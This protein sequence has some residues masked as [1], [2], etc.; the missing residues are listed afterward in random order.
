MLK[1]KKKTKVCK[2][3]T[4]TKPSKKPVK[5]YLEYD[6]VMDLLHALEYSSSDYGSYYYHLFADA[7]GYCE[8]SDNENLVF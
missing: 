7:I 6:E 4:D 5:V 2:C 3:C 1:K 8:P